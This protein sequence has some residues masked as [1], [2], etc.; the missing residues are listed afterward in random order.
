M[1][2]NIEEVEYKFPDEQEVTPVNVET[3]TVQEVK[4]ELETDDKEVDI[5]VVDDTPAQDRDRKPLPKEMVEELEKDE[6]TE[7]SERVKERMAQL[8]KVWHDERREKEAAAREREEAV[9]Y[10]QAVAE[11]NK[12]LKSSLTTGE[13]SYIEVANQAALNEMD[14][15]KREYKEAYDS[16]ESDRVLEAQQRLN[17]AQ[18]KL[19]QAQSY[20][21]QYENALQ[22]DTNNVNIQP[23]RSQVPKP[24]QKA[25]AWQEKNEW[26]GADEEMTSLALGLHEKLVRSGV[27]PASDEYYHRIDD[28]MRKRFPEY[29]EDDSLDEETPAQRTKPSTVVAPVTRSTAPKKVHLTKSAQTIAKKLGLTPEQYVRE[30]IKLEKR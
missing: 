11:E 25:A 19:A 20:R 5:E 9:R 22:D 28:T 26:F 27:N 7:Y 8:K 15:A 17:A 3:S 1:A 6:M 23:Q 10:A 16:G 12:R 24:D 14:I 21:P 2:A 13:Q 18:M 4:I 30:M 29:F